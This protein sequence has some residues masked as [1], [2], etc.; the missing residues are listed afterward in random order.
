M[1]MYWRKSRGRPG[2]VGVESEDVHYVKNCV[3]KMTKG[4]FILGSGSCRQAT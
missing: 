3:H 4:D 2:E 1:K